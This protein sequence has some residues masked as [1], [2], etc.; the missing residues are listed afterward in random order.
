[1]VLFSL[2]FKDGQNSSAEIRRG[3]LWQSRE[4]RDALSLTARAFATRPSFLS[5]NAT[6]ELD[7]VP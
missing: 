3:S 4:E 7:D 1:M 2:C 5:L 6:L